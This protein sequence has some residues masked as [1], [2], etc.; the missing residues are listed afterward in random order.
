MVPPAA[1]AV[2]AFHQRLKARG[3]I[4]TVRRPR[5]DDVSA[6]CGQL[7]AYAQPPRGFAGRS[8]G[9]GFRGRRPAGGSEGGGRGR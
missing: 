2:D 7:R 9:D 3:L 5:G 8:L 1:A 4:A 6:A